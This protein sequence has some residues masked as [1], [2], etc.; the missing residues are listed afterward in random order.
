MRLLRKG[1]HF[2]DI[3]I[4]RYG[5]RAL[6]GGG[7]L[8]AFVAVAIFFNLPRAGFFAVCVGLLIFKANLRRWER[9]SRGKQG[10]S[11][12]TEA[13]RSLPDEYVLLNDLVLP[14]G[15]GNVDHFLI[16]PNGLF[17]IETK[18]YSGLVKCEGFEWYVNRRRIPS[19]TR[20]AKNSA[21]AVRNSLLAP[22]IHPR[23]VAAVIVFT[24]PG[25]KLKLHETV[26]PVVRLDELVEFIRNYKAAGAV[27]PDQVRAIARQLESLEL[28]A[29]SRARA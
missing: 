25:V 10:E 7:A 1:G 11:A 18:N 13:L 23:F 3:R 14:G 12:V 29:R 28:P 17:A 8:L 15:R 6:A 9:W 2:I 16:G 27:S 4:R 19:L 26:V 21:I 20:Q 22:D 24:D 5:A